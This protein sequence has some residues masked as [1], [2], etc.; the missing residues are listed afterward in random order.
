MPD[1]ITTFRA[2]DATE[3][4]IV[5]L[6]LVLTK[7]WGRRVS[8][9]EAIRYAINGMPVTNVGDEELPAPVAPEPTTAVL[10]GQD[11]W[12]W[13]AQGMEA[14]WISEP[15]CATHDLIPRT[16]EG[17]RAWDDGFDPCEHAVRLW[18]EDETVPNPDP[19]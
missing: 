18:P 2:D 1:A 7:T 6:T 19:T 4:R 13:L 17:E 14:G 16:A 5:E 12:G 11:F 9:S 8:R 3:D 10:A 15:F